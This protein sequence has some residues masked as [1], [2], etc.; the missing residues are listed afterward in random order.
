MVRFKGP[1]QPEDRDYSRSCFH[2]TMVRFKAKNT[3]SSGRSGNVSIP[4]WC[5]L[6]RGPR[7]LPGGAAPGFHPTM[8]RF[9]G[10][11]KFNGG[12]EN[13]PVSIP[14]WCDLKP[15]RRPPAV[16]L[17]SLVSIPLWCDLKRELRNDAI[18]YFQ[19]SIPLWCDLKASVKGY[20]TTRDVC[21]HPTMVR[22]KGLGLE[23][24]DDAVQRFH[25]TMVRFKA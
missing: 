23:R 22:F 14:L 24:L 21:F 3:G 18:G 6:K 7:L 25:P 10:L 15:L 20:S 17:P 8:V 19:V 5:D 9:K 1:G 4:L 11:Y 16:P 12:D 2:P 13:D